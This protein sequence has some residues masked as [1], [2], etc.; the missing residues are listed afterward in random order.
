MA[1]K[2]FTKIIDTQYLYERFYQLNLKRLGQAGKKYKS[3]LKFLADYPATFEFRCEEK[4][5]WIRL[6]N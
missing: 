2:K 1:D 6:K 5:C 3:R 4:T